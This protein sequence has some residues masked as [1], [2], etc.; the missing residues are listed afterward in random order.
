MVRPIGVLNSLLVLLEGVS[1]L[2]LVE[3]LTGA[4]VLRL[5]KH[6]LVQLNNSFVLGWSGVRFFLVLIL[7][8]VFKLIAVFLLVLI[9]EVDGLK[10]LLHCREIVA[11]L[12]GQ[13]TLLRLL[14]QRRVVRLLHRR[15][16]LW[17]LHRHRLLLRHGH[18]LN[19]GLGYSECVGGGR[20]ARVQLHD[21][22]LEEGH[23]LR[24]RHRPALVQ[25]HLDVLQ[26]DRLGEGVGATRA[27]K[28][29]VRA[30]A[31]AIIHL[32]TAGRSL[33]NGEAFTAHRALVVDH[34][35]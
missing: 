7:L 28:L 34:E 10:V 19:A 16:N 32:K 30:A 35:V 15:L 21:R 17:H 12:A 5:V 11:A 24:V 20:H 25:A 9:V 31:G 27:L 8:V 3:V 6:A 14:V 13:G 33:V 18:H 1:E 4:H 22:S 29:V 2:V 23:L 26:S